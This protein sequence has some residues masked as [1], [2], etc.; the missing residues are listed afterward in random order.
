MKMSFF[1]FKFDTQCQS[2]NSL[3]LCQAS[4]AAVAFLSADQVSALCF[5]YHHSSSLN[6][7]S[8]IKQLSALTQESWL[9]SSSDF[10]VREFSTSVSAKN[11]VWNCCLTKSNEIL[12][13]HICCQHNDTY[14]KRINWMTK[15]WIS[16][17]VFFQIEHNE[18]SYS[19]K[20]CKTKMKKIMILR[21]VEHTHEKSETE[22]NKNNWTMTVNKWINIINVYNVLQQQSQKSTTETEKKYKK[23]ANAK[24]NLFYCLNQKKLQ[25]KKSDQKKQQIQ[26]IS[27]S[28]ENDEQEIIFD[29]EIIVL[30]LFAFLI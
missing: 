9:L 28:D 17:A 18:I 13:T 15:F 3:F 5:E 26:E 10:K 22:S 16:I 23:T 8:L 7:V 6:S 29:E 25:V 27:N 21:Q 19:H 24:K 12:L 30:K 14:E 1:F 4:S 20:F 11:D 2:F